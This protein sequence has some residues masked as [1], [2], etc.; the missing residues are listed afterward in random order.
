MATFSP[1]GET[2]PVEVEG[3]VRESRDQQVI[4]VGHWSLK[5]LRP[6]Y[7]LCDAGQIVQPL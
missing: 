2:N 7:P 4:D 3:T 6:V 5:G 1:A